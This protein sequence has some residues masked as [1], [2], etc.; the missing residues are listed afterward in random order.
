MRLDKYLADMGIGTRK[1]IKKLIL[2]G[3]V[4]VD[5]EII[6]KPDHKVDESS[7]VCLEG[8]A[9][10][11]QQYQYFLLNK[12]AGYL[13]TKD[14][15]PNVMELVPNYYKDLNPVG[16]LDKDTEGLLIIT[17]DGQLTHQLISPKYHVDKKYYFECDKPLPADA[18]AV[19]S[20]PIEFSDFISL[21]GKL[22]LISENSGYL[23]IHEGK[24]HQVRRMI[25]YLGC[26]VTYLKRTNYSFLDIED[27]A[28]GEYRE[29]T[30]EETEK[31]KGV[32]DNE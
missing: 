29:L 13:C 32:S 3:L 26:N 19:L 28:V 4:T 17:N 14:G 16:R 5:D 15:S 21:P 10:I 6:T 7:S 31:L 9:L 12:P 8:E 18:A 27:L 2:A 1:E 11:Y 22:E 20:K 23:T 24:F 30:A 25:G